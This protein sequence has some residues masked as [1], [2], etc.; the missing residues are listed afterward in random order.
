MVYNIT[1]VAHIYCAHSRA[2]AKTIFLFISAWQACH[3][4]EHKGIKLIKLI[5]EMKKVNN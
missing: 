3:I 2:T 5:K 1:R 4:K